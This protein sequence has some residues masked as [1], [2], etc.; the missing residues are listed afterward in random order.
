ME[1]ADR[2]QHVADFFQQRLRRLEPDACNIAG[3][4]QILGGQCRGSCLNPEIGKA[5][6]ENVG[7]D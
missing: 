6:K 7:E 1:E 2:P 3:T 5:R 4:H